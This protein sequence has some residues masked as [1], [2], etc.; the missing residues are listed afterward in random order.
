MDALVNDNARLRGLLSSA[1]AEEEEHAR[2]ADEL[3]A[4]RDAAAERA[5]AMERE[6]AEL[7]ERV[8]EERAGR[9]ALVPREEADRA[10]KEAEEHQELMIVDTPAGPGTKAQDG[11]VGSEI[12][13][14]NKLVLRT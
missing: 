12:G 5:R 7:R 10:A 8:E 9:D 2:R 14:K 6:L 13:G 1:K 3:R 4:D 11:S